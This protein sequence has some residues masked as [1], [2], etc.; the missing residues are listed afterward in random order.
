MGQS[1]NS[2]IFLGILLPEHDEC[3]ETE[4]EISL[5]DIDQ[6]LQKET[7]FCL[8]QHC[9]GECPMWAIAIKA[10]VS[11]AR[12]GYPQTFDPHQMV[13]LDVYASTKLRNAAEKY[14]L[15]LEGSTRSA[16]W[17]HLSHWN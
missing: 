4:D 12:R 1:T 7:D 17:Y 6:Q 3:F 11:E 15:S 8:V 5:W 16:N 10:S 13:K 14:G 2:I 9:S